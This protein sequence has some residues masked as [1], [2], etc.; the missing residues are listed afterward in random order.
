M[1]PRGHPPQTP[2]HNVNQGT[3][4]PVDFPRSWQRKKSAPSAQ[5]TPQCPSEVRACPCWACLRRRDISSSVRQLQ[6]ATRDHTGHPLLLQSLC[7]HS[8]LADCAQLQPVAPSRSHSPISPHTRFQARP[9]AV[10]AQ[11]ALPSKTRTQK[12]DRGRQRRQAPPT[13]QALPHPGHSGGVTETKG[14]EVGGE[15]TCHSLIASAISGI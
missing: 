12:T 13:C 7:P 8:T 9:G 11:E 5:Q 10:K 1:R 4:L 6:M 3:F 15:G 2:E 14:E